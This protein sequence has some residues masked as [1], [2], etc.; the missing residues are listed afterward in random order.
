MLLWPNE[1]CVRDECMYVFTAER[2]LDGQGITATNGWLWAPGYITVLAAHL[3]VSEWITGV[4]N[5]VSGS[6]WGLQMLCALGAVWLLLD[7]G[8]RAF[9]ERTGRIAAALYALSPTFIF[10]TKQLWS[11]AI[12]GPMILLLVWALVRLREKGRWWAC[13][14]GA[15]AGIC[16]LF[17]GVAVYMTPLLLWVVLWRRTRQRAAWI[18]A[19]ILLG[20]AAAVVTPYSM[21]ATDKFGTSIISD[22]SLGQ[23]MWLGNN[24]FAPVTFDWGNGQIPAKKLARHTKNGRERCAP[25]SK[26][27]KRDACETAAGV[28]WIKTHPDEFFGRIPLR[29]AQTMNPHSFLTRHLRW[30]RWKGLPYWLDETLIGIV[31]L[32]SMAASWGAAIGAWGRGGGPTLIGATIMTA[33]HLA[34]C[35]ALAGLTR[36]RVPIEP[37]WFLFAAAAFSQP[38][39]C[40]DT[41]RTSK[42]R[43]IG[44][45]ITLG[46]VAWTTLWFLPVGFK[47][48]GQW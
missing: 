45:L 31:V 43:A 11:E 21:Y 16:V 20:V 18:H 34:A 29:V 19:A 28:E 9:D 37:L 35:A 1:S 40:W 27:M 8:R 32:F 14:S 36:Y 42:V 6:I 41:L 44:C 33:Y 3:G 7:L 26:P 15:L 13:G 23:M 47:W 39:A 48:W 12:Y 5:G 17:K 4:E 30:K 10:F 46:L 2:M 22:R 25:K 24:D 38:R